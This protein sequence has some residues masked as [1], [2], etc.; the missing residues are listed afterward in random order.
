MPSRCESSSLPVSIET[1]LR[2]PLLLGE[3]GASENPNELHL[4]L[5]RLLRQAPAVIDVAWVDVSGVQQAKV[6]RIGRD[7]IGPGKDW[8]HDPG[9]IAARSGAFYA[10]PVYFRAESEPYA[11]FAVGD[12]SGALLAEVNLK[13]VWEVVSAIKVGKS[14]YAYVVDSDGRLISHPDIG[15]VLKKT[16][17]S[18][19]SQVHAALAAA[20]NSDGNLTITMADGLGAPA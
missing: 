13:F 18:Q 11:V 19:L 4:E 1:Q 20:G 3:A 12:A 8:S 14:G 10:S 5:V 15:L 6:S 2:A 9:F 16:D 17:L 7:E